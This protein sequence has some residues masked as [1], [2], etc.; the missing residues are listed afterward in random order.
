MGSA[1]EV[2]LHHRLSRLELDV[3][4][5]AGRETLALVGPSGSGKSTILRAIAGLLRPN[6]G[7]VVSGPRVLLDTE[8]GIDVPPEDRRAGLVFQDGALFPFLTV[9]ANVAY[10]VRGERRSREERARSTLNQF[11]IAHLADAKPPGLSGGERQRVALARAIASEPEIL[12]LDEPL[13][14]LDAVT[15]G[16]V[17]SELELRLS[18]A[19]LPAILVSHDF[20]DVLGLADRVVVIH[21]GRVVQSG[22]PAE[23]VEAPASRFVASLA[24]VNYFVGEASRRGDLTEVRGEG[25]PAAIR[26]VDDAEGSVGVVVY[27]WEVSIALHVPGGSALN[28]VSGAV[29]RI[30]LVGN[31]AR[32]AVDSRPPVV[33]EVTEESVRHLNLGLGAV[34]V[35][36]WKATSTRLVRP[37]AGATPLAHEGSNM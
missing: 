4:F 12:L 33:A 27:P 3:A 25:W 17:A 31:R 22:R 29:R 18:E 35:A 36:S 19:A 10:G 8:R 34:V 23:L 26:S 28:A 20:T 14:A 5:S 15:R 11:G 9:L 6:K 30:A 1:L 2:D 24:G 13:S 16:E 37:P 32:V 21:D 7:K